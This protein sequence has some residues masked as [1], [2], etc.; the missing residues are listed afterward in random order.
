[1]AGSRG[2]RALDLD[3][4]S[5]VMLDHLVDRYAPHSWPV[6][7]VRETGT[8]ARE[9]RQVD[10]APPILLSRSDW[11][12]TPGDALSVLNVR[13]GETLAARVYRLTRRG[14]A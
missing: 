10:G 9:V 14:D 13:T 11:E 7:A 2:R 6:S 1:M 4:K 12:A 5:V 3:R 8:A